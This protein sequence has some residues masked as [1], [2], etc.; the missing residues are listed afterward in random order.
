MT[1]RALNI[2]EAGGPDAYQYA[3]GAL[4]HDT[5]EYWQDCLSDPKPPGTA[6]PRTY[7]RPR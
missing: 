5:R 1:E 7:G 4:R 6:G 2:L 3:L